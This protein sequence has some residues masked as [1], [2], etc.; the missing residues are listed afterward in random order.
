[1]ALKQNKWHMNFSKT[2]TKEKLK[3]KFTI[4]NL[5]PINNNIKS[6]NNK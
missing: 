5:R 2:K 3:R 1:M 4:Y 6:E